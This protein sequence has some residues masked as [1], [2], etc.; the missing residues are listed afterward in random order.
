MAG[1]YYPPNIRQWDDC[2]PACNDAF[3]RVRAA[4]GDAPV[5]P[6]IRDVRAWK[7]KMDTELPL[8]LLQSEGFMNQ[9]RAS[10]VIHEALQ[11]P[12]QCVMNAYLSA[13]G[14]ETRLYYDSSSR[15]KPTPKTRPD[16]LVLASGTSSLPPDADG[17]AGDAE[18]RVKSI[19]RVLMGE[20]KP[21]HRISAAFLDRLAQNP[22][23]EDVMIQLATASSEGSRESERAGPEAESDIHETAL[24]AGLTP[25]YVYFAN[26]LTQTFHY[27]VTSGLKYDFLTSG[28]TLTFLKLPR[29]DPTTLLVHSEGFPKYCQPG[30]EETGDSDIRDLPVARLCGLS[31]LAYE[32]TPASA[33]QRSVDIS[34]LS[35]FPNLPPC[36]SPQ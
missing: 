34:Q 26:A 18:D 36:N 24:A 16:C 19:Y 21:L 27:M 31:L 6:S 10:H 5:F 4:I 20:H 35:V 29:H 15:D 25:G 22:L 12:A 1:K 2:R 30:S 14:F 17:L 9:A 8:L 33:R 11:A 3:E 28:E 23:P 13:S 32:S 7:R